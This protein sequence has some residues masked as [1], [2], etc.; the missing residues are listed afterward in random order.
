MTFS[1]SYSGNQ[2]LLKDLAQIYGEIDGFLIEQKEGYLNY[3]HSN[4]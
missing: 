3:F 2:S 1:V 4:E